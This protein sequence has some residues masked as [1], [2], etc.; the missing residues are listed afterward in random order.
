MSEGSHVYNSQCER[1]SVVSTRVCPPCDWTPDEDGNWHTGCGEEHV[2]NEGGP[3][4]N[5]MRFCCY[6]GQMLNEK[7]ART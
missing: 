5:R 6:C 4:D 3:D 7:A 1:V 2:L